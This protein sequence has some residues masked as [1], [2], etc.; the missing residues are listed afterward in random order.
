MSPRASQATA[1][2]MLWAAAAVA[3]PVP[4]GDE[5]QVNTYTTGNRSSGLSVAHE[6]G[7]FV[8]V[9]AGAGAGDSDGG[10]F[11]QR[12]DASGSFLGSEFQVSTTVP[13]QLYRSEVSAA[14]SGG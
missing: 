5:F 1:L 11:G 14:P 10:V 7:R 12:L 4:L 13:A 6:A 9:W 8:V 3:Q 2:L